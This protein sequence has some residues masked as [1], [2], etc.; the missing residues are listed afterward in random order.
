MSIIHLFL[1]NLILLAS[2]L[3]LISD[4]NLQDQ[5]RLCILYDHQSDHIH[6]EVDPD[7]TS[8]EFTIAKAGFETEEKRE[9]AIEEYFNNKRSYFPIFQVFY[10]SVSGPEYVQSLNNVDCKEIVSVNK[11]RDEELYSQWAYFIEKK[12]NQEYLVWKSTLEPEE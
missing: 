2:S 9:Q 10:Y 3:S 5:P 8:A 7:S 6:V 4:Q 1:L 11:L 12:A